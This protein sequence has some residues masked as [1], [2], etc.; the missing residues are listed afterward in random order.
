MPFVRTMVINHLPFL[1]HGLQ[2]FGRCVFFNPILRIYDEPWANEPLKHVL[3]E[4]TRYG[5]AFLPLVHVCFIQNLD[6]CIYVCVFQK[7]SEALKILNYGV[8]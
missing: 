8:L 7:D 2:P 4:L 3:D 6:V 1:S 5:H